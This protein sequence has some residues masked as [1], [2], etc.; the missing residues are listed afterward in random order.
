MSAK[1]KHVR[2]VI[3]TRPTSAFAQDVIS[4]GVDKKS[5]HIHIP[6]NAE[7]GFINN[8][9]ENWDFKFDNILH[10]AS[11]EVVYDECGSSIV[12][13][14]LDG[15]NGTVMA[16][17][18]TGAGKTFTMTGATENYKHR[19]LIPR[20]ISH[21]FHEIAERP[22]LA[23]T[24]RISYLE[25]YN[26]QMVD[27]LATLS[28][29]ERSDALTV[30]EEKTG[31]TYVKGLTV[32]IAN[33]EEEA[34]NLL[35]EGETNRSIS[36]H[37]LNKNSTRYGGFRV[38][39]SHCI[40]TIYVE[41][42]SRV[43]SSEKVM[44]S[45]L[46]LV[47]LAGSE[48]LSKT[49]TKGK[50]LKEAM[51]INRS[52]TYLEQVIIALSD[53]KREHIPFRQS[54]MTHVLR[55]AL[56]GNCNTLMIANIWGEQEHIEETISTLR[57]ATRMMCVSTSPEI[58]VQYDPIA[59]IKKYEKE[60][61]EL[62]QEL[63]MH[64]TLS[65]RS[66]VQYEPYT[67][68]QKHE[69]AKSVRGFI[70]NE[71]EEIEIVSLRQIR[72]VLTIFR[73]MYKNLESEMEDAMQRA[74]K[75]SNTNRE[76]PG[77]HHSE[78]LG[79]TR[80]QTAYDPDREDGVGDVESAGFGVG[81]APLGVRAQQLQQSGMR[82]GGAAMRMGTQQ[83]KG[84]RKMGRISAADHD[85][86]DF[87]HE[88]SPSHQLPRA[89]DMTPL[90]ESELT[91]TIKYESG[92]IIDTTQGMLGGL[93]APKERRHGGAPL[94]RAEEFE[95]FKRGKGAEMNRIL[96]DNK[97][98]LKEKR[99][100]AKELAETVNQIKITMDD[101]KSRLEQN[102]RANAGRE[103]EIII[104]EEEYAMISSIKRLKEQYREKFDQLRATRA[105]VEYCT[106]LTDQCRQKLMAE[107]EQWYESIYGAQMTDA[108]NGG[109]GA[110]AGAGAGG[111][112]MA[113]GV[114]GIDDALDI[115]EKF[116]RLQM[117]RMSQ[118]DP[119]SLPYYNAKKNT[120]RRNQKP[121]Q[122]MYEFL[123]AVT[124]RSALV[125]GVPNQVSTL[126][127]C[128]GLLFMQGVAWYTGED[129]E[130]YALVLIK[131]SAAW[132]LSG[133][134][135]GGLVAAVSL[136]RFQPDWNPRTR[137]WPSGP[138]LPAVFLSLREIVSALA[139]LFVPLSDASYNII[140]YGVGIERFA[141][142]ILLLFGLLTASY[143]YIDTKQMFTAAAGAGGAPLRKKD[144]KK[145]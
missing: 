38:D 41:S 66:H 120:E 89:G 11:Q 80:K 141:L 71:A 60:I 44:I 134:V 42:R 30:V 62:K 110:G 37:Q 14:L 55:D 72:E 18:Q 54:K 67:E 133:F 32:Q 82:G 50:S 52:L 92:I 58:N 114:G 74:Q 140:V 130:L 123:G 61:K 15:Y 109:G 25:V 113:M 79:A 106:K 35:F 53:K 39:T 68:A 142:S 23:F 129:V 112:G 73:L 2:V 95:T 22:T 77:E 87:A 84:N 13:S 98:V 100:L 27:L 46:N 59:L 75:A 115:G 83:A 137:A 99:R 48:R 4:F 78:S 12:R 90:R 29:G 69:L 26:E 5:L 28:D 76:S 131:F 6:K 139:S 128:L 97:L 86:D 81:L 121:N 107:F 102:K 51:Y 96:T 64:D 10:N 132:L 145:Q 57:F 16:Y 45:K 70:D 94:S 19:G 136:M 122:P 118:E 36:E 91:F 40:F 105:D 104:S 116:D 20:A 49:E 56:G 117:E 88:V 85:D 34:L 135:F 3:R 119:D 143:W 21:V 8:Q 33:N 43:E 93:G 103:S 24:V 31:S 125:E 144:K 126:S 1:S 101:Y 124:A 108:S 63:S 7:W 111:D 9:Q 138:R 127:A 65:N 17:G 47:D